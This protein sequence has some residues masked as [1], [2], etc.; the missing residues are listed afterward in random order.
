MVI[1]F[2]LPILFIFTTI[3]PSRLSASEEEK[4]YSEDLTKETLYLLVIH[5]SKQ[6]HFE[7]LVRIL[8]SEL[9]P[10]TYNDTVNSTKRY[11]QFSFGNGQTFC[12]E[13]FMPR[14]VTSHF[15]TKRI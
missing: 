7:D 2:L 5:D 12:Y 8:E 15:R 3:P 4:A 14:L 6:S 9:N 11:C 13:D 1:S 10:E